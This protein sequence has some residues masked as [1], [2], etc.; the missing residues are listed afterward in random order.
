[1]FFILSNKVLCTLII[2]R[3][4]Q[5]EKYLVSGLLDGRDYA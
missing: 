5:P 2:A 4:R 1:M 3:S